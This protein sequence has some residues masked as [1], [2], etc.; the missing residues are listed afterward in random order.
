[1]RRLLLGPAVLVLSGVVLTAQA[2]SSTDW[3]QWRGPN[4][5]GISRETGLLQAWPKTGPPLVWSAADLGAGFGS[6]AVR[7]DRVFVQ[8]LRGR[9]SIVT[10]LQRSSGK[11]VWSKV[12]GE[13]RSNDR[14]PGPRGTP[15]LDADRLYVLTENG[16]LACLRVQDGTRI[17][18]RNI[19]ADFR[20]DLPNWLISESPLVDGNLV[21]VSPGGRDA[22][23]VALDKLSGKTVWQSRGL[24]DEASYAS[25]I[26]AD[27]H[28]IR[29]V[30]AFTGQAGVGLRLSD[31]SLLWRYREPSNRTANAA[32][33]IY[34]DGRVFYTSNYGVGAGLLA[35]R[36]AA[37]GIDT[38]E[39]YFT[40]DM[41]NHHGGV[42]L[43]DGYLYGYNNAILTC[44]EF[45]TGKMMWRDRSVGKG[46]IT[47]ADGHLYIVGENQ[48]VGLVEA[49]PAGYREKGRFTIKDEGWN[50]WAHPVVAGGTLFIRNQ[51]TLTTYDVRAR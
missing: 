34:A 32:T 25:A 46:A 24:S 44:L 42:V 11:P 2:P 31:G 5:D 35:L 48:T 15:T 7:D 30:I 16:D 23:V 4:R 1:M 18:Q 20:G 22:A 38:N 45:A 6:V 27:V 29:T 39:V 40:R 33:P 41:Q 37:G 21:I 13:G 51:G 36:P 28:G 12:I 47:Y 8:G 3:P 9:Q 10:A 43:V 14:G 19:L 49:T 17:W 26:V 50:S